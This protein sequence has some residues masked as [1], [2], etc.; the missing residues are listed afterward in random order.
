MHHGE[1][2]FAHAFPSAPPRHIEKSTLGSQI[3]RWQLAARERPPPPPKILY[4]R[5][6]A[7]VSQPTDEG[8]SEIAN[9]GPTNFCG[10]AFHQD[11][12]EIFR[13]GP[14]TVKTGERHK[15]WV[16]LWDLKECEGTLLRITPSPCPSLSSGVLPSSSSFNNPQEQL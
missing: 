6:T 11:R 13:E 2:K 16:C 1:G 4:P 8:R 5:T 12:G 9:R 14:R 10:V 7:Q 3:S 15:L